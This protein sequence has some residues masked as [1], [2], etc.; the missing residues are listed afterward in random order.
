MKMGCS[1]EY[2]S[3]GGR[4]SNIVK[5][6]LFVILLKEKE[7]KKKRSWGE[8]RGG[9][10]EGIGGETEGGF[11]EFCNE[12]QGAREAGETVVIVAVVECSATRGV[13]LDVVPSI[14][15]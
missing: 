5:A 15:K 14:T 13:A 2:R 12:E 1:E 9:G 4:F 6:L 11:V 10:R 3:L 7:R 8:R